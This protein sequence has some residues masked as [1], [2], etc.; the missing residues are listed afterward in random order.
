MAVDSI[1]QLVIYCSHLPNQF[2]AHLKM[3]APCNAYC[4]S[5]KFISEGLT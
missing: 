5:L 4:Y 1:L 3:A 2:I